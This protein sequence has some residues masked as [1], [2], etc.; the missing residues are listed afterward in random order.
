M[1]TKSSVL[2]LVAA[3]L[4]AAGCGETAPDWETA[5]PV[6]AIPEPPLGVKG[7]IDWEAL[8]KQQGLEVTAEKIRLGR[9]LFF[10]GRLSADGTISCATCHRPAN[11]FSEPTPTSTGIK[12][13]VGDRK[14]PPVVNAAFVIYPVYFWDGRA[15]TLAEQ[16]KGPIE[17]PIEMGNTHDT[18]VET[19]ADIEGYRRPFEQAF[20]DS[21]VTIDRIAD[22][23]AAYEATLFSG[24]SPWDRFQAGDDDAVSEQV[25]EGNKLF[26]NKAECNQ[27]HLGFNF[28]DSKFH[29]LGIGWDLDRKAYKDEGRKK[30]TGKTEDL[31]AF[32]TPS[33]RDVALH[34]PY[35][36]DGSMKTLREV[37]EHYVKGGIPGAANLSSK[38]RKLELT[39]EEIDAIVAFMEAL[40]GDDSIRKQAE[41]SALPR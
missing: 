27:C 25:M 16:A 24:N 18:A 35:M 31:G 7:K 14:A 5:N 8:K 23:I 13:Q 10:D 4:V 21:E 41:P 1:I 37:V 36:H 32:K 40:T 38:V 28:T 19:I 34:A 3:A 26:H 20:G 22:A 39:E 11:A 15:A 9:W 33:L 30:H 17:N 29:S 6:A 12:G 2:G